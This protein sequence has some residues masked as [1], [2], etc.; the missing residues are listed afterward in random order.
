MFNFSYRPGISRGAF[1]ERQDQQLKP[2]EAALKNLLGAVKRRRGGQLQAGRRFVA[3]VEAL[4]GEFQRLSEAAFAERC[5]R[6]QAALRACGAN[7]DTAIEAFAAVREAS[8]RLLGKRHFTTQLLGGWALLQGYVAEMQTGEGKTLTTL[9]PACTAAMA[10]MPVHVITANDYL[11]ARDAELLKPVFAHFDLKVGVLSESCKEAAARRAVFECNVVFTSPSQI[12]FDYLRDRLAMGQRRGGLDLRIHE[13]MSGGHDSPSLLMRG[14]CFAIVDEA[15]SVLIDDACTPLI[16]SQQN[17]QAPPPEPYYQAIELARRLEKGTDFNVNVKYHQVNIEPSGQKKLASL[18]TKV[19]A[20]DAEFQHTLATVKLALQA[21]YCYERD[22]TYIV[23]DEKIVIIDNNTGRPHPDHAW[24]GG[25]H[26]MV[27]AKEGLE[28]SAPRETIARMSYQRF[29]KRYLHLSGMSGTVSEVAGELWSVYELEVVKIPTHKPSRRKYYGTDIYAT[30]A[31][32][33]QKIVH[34]I[35][36]LTECNRAILIGTRSVAESEALSQVLHQAKLAHRVLNAR[37]DDAEAEIIA[38]AGDVNAVTVATGMAGRGTDI[39]LADAVH[40]AGGLHVILASKSDSAR[41]DRQL[42]GRCARQG[43]PGSWQA[44]L[45]L[46]D[47][48]LQKQFPQ[49]LIMLGRVVWQMRLHAFARLILR[50][51]QRRAEHRDRQLRRSVQRF[52]DSSKERFAF[53]GPME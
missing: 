40:D 27:E 53:S 9:L 24:E 52:D 18:S 46:D 23:R 36:R 33:W 31:Q 6:I 50:L 1:P 8:G 38:A 51:A 44:I 15:D 4:D 10:G 19:H 3:E 20:N 35:K 47:E 17:G 49:S 13:L 37:Q 22:K 45:S 14:L 12:A 11:A 41:A 7:P 32:K 2:L 25:L 26:Q 21:L 29:F 42:V 5:Q 39:A 16:L 34:R 48:I 43:D 30:E 28:L